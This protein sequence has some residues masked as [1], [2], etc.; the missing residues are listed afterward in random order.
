MRFLLMTSSLIRRRPG[1]MLNLVVALESTNHLAK[2]R[3]YQLRR[4]VQVLQLRTNT[5]PNGSIDETGD[6]ICIL[7]SIHIFQRRCSVVDT[8][9]HVHLSHAHTHTYT[10]KHHKLQGCRDCVYVDCVDCFA[11]TLL[12]LH[13]HR[14]RWWQRLVQLPWC[15]VISQ[16][17]LVSRRGALLVCADVYA[18]MTSSLVLYCTLGLSIQADTGGLRKSVNENIYE[19]AADKPLITGT[20]Q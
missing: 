3:T 4:Q 17:Q 2:T 10:C 8:R 14:G 1:L 11:C 18:I 16:L 9:A 6:C 12:R 5:Y 19:D 13:Q 15:S 20:V 7:R